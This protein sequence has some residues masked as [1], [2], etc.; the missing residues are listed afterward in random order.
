MAFDTRV[1]AF[2]RRDVW[3]RTMMSQKDARDYA[4]A[5]FSANVQYRL[6]KAP[7]KDQLRL[8][9][10]LSPTDGA[11]VMLEL[12]QLAGLGFISYANLTGRR[13]GR[14]L[15]LLEAFCLHNAAREDPDE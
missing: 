15:E 4:V 2:G 9:Y 6:N 10:E 5:I 13:D 14:E 8:V 1:L 11:D 7:M 12:A 3:S